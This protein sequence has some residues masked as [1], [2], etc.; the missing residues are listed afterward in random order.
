VALGIHELGL[1]GTMLRR[2]GHV[3]GD[4]GSAVAPEVLA[5]AVFA[6]G[7]IL[8]VS[9]VMPVVPSRVELVAS[10]LPLIV[11]E[12]AHVLASVVG[13][14]LVVLAR[15]VQRRVAAAYGATIALLTA[16]I[17]L[18][19]VKGL[20]WEEALVVAVTLAAFVPCRSQL[21]RRTTGLGERLTPGWA[22]GVLVAVGATVWLFVFVHRHTAAAPELWWQVAVR[23]TGPRAVRAIAAVLVTGLV[24]GAWML[25][26]PTVRDAARSDAGA[27]ARAE[28]I[29]AASPTAMAALALVGDKHLLFADDARAFVMYGVHGRSWIAL[30]DPIGADDDA[31]ELTWRFS[32]LVDGYDALCAFH[33]VESERLPLYLDLG[34]TLTRLGDEGRVPLADFSL[35]GARRA[36]LRDRIERLEREGWSARIAEPD[37]LGAR[38]AELRAV[39]DACLAAR[40]AREPGFTFG[41]FAPDYVRRFPAALVERD[42]TLVA[43]ATMLRSGRNAELAIDV[44]RAAPSAPPHAVE[45]LLAAA[46]RWGQAHGY[47]WFDLGMAPAAGPPDPSPAPGWNR[48]QPLLYR[49]GAHFVDAGGLRAFAERLDAVWAPRYLAAP[50]GLALTRVLAD[51]T[52]LIAGARDGADAR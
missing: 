1:R 19:L 41:R 39:S 28:P 24:A 32:E 26:R 15:D 7:T 40:H 18:L 35:D 29:V 2:V 51:L 5:A 16:G 30:G 3:V 11:I 31:A 44:M 14:G 47:A 37:E 6:S 46:M 45:L 36:P 23:A 20:A 38:M 33:A 9:G 42:G 13:L 4:W 22:A 17:V 48:L 50:G 25:R 27:I 8:L 52:A 34:L 21:Y 10:V 12:I 43:F 49:H